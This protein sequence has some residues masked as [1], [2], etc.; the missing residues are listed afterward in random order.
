VA[1]R[2]YP[3]RAERLAGDIDRYVDEARAA[4]AG[5]S[6]SATSPRRASQAPEQSAAERRV[7]GVVAPHAGIVYSGPTAGFAYASIDPAAVG[8]VV[9]L[10]PAHYVPVNGIG[11]SS[12]GAWRTPL[13]DVELDR[14]VAAELAAQLTTVVPADDAHAPEHS[15]EVQV[16][17]L[18][19]VLTGGWQLVPLIV[20]ADEP[21]E[22]AAAITF[23]VGLPGTLVVVSTDLSHYLDYESAIARDARTIHAI[24]HRRP[25]SIGTEDACGRYPLRG[26][27]S[28][29]AQKEWSVRLLDASNSGDTAGDRDRVVGYAAFAVLAAS[30]PDPPGSGGPD[31]GRGADS[32]GVSAGAG[33][34]PTDPVGLEPGRGPGLEPGPGRGPG[35]EVGR[36]PPDSRA[37]LLALARSTISDALDTG[38]RPAFDDSQWADPVLTT[39]GA[40]FVTLRS[41]AGDL[42]GCIGSLEPRQPLVADVAEHAFDAAFR[43]PRFPSMTRDRAAGMVI[44]ISVLSPTRP[45]PS[46]GYEDLV[47]RIPVGS[48]VVV[49][50]GRHRATFL[51]AVWEQLPDARSFLAALWRKAGLAPGEWPRGT[52]VEV[53]DSEEFAEA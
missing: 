46:S 47:S 4:L 38:R 11:L 18:Q 13:G 2:F 28:A 40:A 27:L 17:F 19:R 7:L 49:T 41:E 50:A 48:G 30:E 29:A 3:G 44:D 37:L 8:R 9:L 53:Y 32:A 16:P 21:G 33:T 10:G 45:F 22:I 6:S 42:L 20:G 25:D 31:Q 52:R 51:P 34:D 14:D 24:V 39:P 5:R 12:A 1:G 23:C 35:P 15:L 26:L 36:I 43:D